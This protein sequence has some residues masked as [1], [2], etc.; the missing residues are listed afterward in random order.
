MTSEVKGW[1]QLFYVRIMFFPFI[2]RQSRSQEDT[3]VDPAALRGLVPTF[4]ACV[5]GLPQ[6]RD[7]RTFGPHNAAAD[8]TTPGRRLCR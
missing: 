4:L 3:T 7:A 1:E 8:D 6:A 5:G 2:S